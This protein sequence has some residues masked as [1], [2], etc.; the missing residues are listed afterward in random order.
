MLSLSKVFQLIVN[1]KSM[2]DFDFDLNKLSSIELVPDKNE[3]KFGGY[4]DV[5]EINFEK[6]TEFEA[7]GKKII[8]EY[9][10]EYLS[11]K[12]SERVVPFRMSKNAKID[13]TNICNHLKKVI[14]EGY[15]NRLC[16][17]Y[18]SNDYIPKPGN[19]N[20][21]SEQEY[22]AFLLTQCQV[23]NT[24]PETKDLYKTIKTI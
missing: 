10:D 8:I 19:P 11:T 5:P 22:A 20:V 17:C 15:I 1:N 14:N 16:Y 2:E 9:L 18:E 21:P 24:I 4:V 23:L 7:T 12:A 13:I 6:L 3:I